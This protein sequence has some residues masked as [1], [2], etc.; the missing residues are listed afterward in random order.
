[1]TQIQFLKKLV[2][3]KVHNNKFNKNWPTL[4]IIM[5]QMNNIMQNM[6]Q[7]TTKIM[8]YKHTPSFKKK[9]YMKKIST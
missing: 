8:N 2:L 3:G 5:N 1:M 4:R 6:I 7:M 9:N